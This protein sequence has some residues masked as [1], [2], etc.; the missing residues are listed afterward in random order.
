MD[1]RPDRTGRV[2]KRAGPAGDVGAAVIELVVGLCLFV[3]PVAAVVSLLPRWFEAQQDVSDAARQGIRLAVLTSSS[4]DEVEQ[5]V[6]TQLAH[7]RVDVES[8][9]VALEPDAA[10]IDVTYRAPL[11]VIPLLGEVGGIAR[12]V[13]H[14]EILDPYRSRSSGG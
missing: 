9:A 8:V 2:R 12:T 10:V 14:V 13:R 6:L 3:V 4:P 5:A 1:S 7:E 11:L